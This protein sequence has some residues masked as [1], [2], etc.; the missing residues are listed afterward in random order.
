M[1]LRELFEKLPDS[2][3]HGDSSVSI[4]GLTC[5]SRSV[6]PGALFFALHGTQADGHRYIAKAVAT[7]AAAVV[8]EDASSAPDS[9]PW[10]KVSDGR[11]AM[12]LISAIFNGDPTA[13]KPLIGITGT[14]GKTTTTYLIEA[15]M[16]AAGLQTAVLGT[17]S[18]R[19][20]TATIAASHTTPESTELQRA[21]KQLGDAGAQAFVMEV[22]SH[23][24]EQLSLIH[25]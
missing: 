10:V 6:Q 18:Y 8:L 11:A 17:I 3:I 14:N 16:A 5:D 15:V 7:G 20:G 22:S 13:V 24:L 1:T 12:G 25:I 23:A 9:L 2:E 19:Y 21:L 4:S